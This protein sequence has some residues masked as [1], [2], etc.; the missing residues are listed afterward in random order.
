MTAALNFRLQALILKL[1]QNLRKHAYWLAVALL[2]GMLLSLIIPEAALAKCQPDGV[3]ERAGAGLAGLLDAR[4][5]TMSGNSLYGDYGYA[6]LTWHACDLGGPIAGNEWAG[7]PDAMLDTT[8][9]NAGLGLAKWIAALASGLHAWNSNPSE[10]L[11]PFD[12]TLVQL[13]TFVRE[14]VVEEWAIVS[15]LI[16][17]AFMFV[18][19]ITKEAR[20]AMVSILIFCLAT[21]FLAIVGAQPLRVAQS[22]D[23]VAASIVNNADQRSLAIA[24]IDAAPEEAI[25]AILNDQILYP[26]WAKGALGRDDQTKAGA[27]TYATRLYKAQATT[28]DEANVSAE[29]K[30]NEYEDIF[31]ELGDSED[32]QMQD[33]LRGK[34]YYNRSAMGVGAAIIAAL[35]AGIRIVSEF[36][37]FASVLIFRFIPII[38][39]I[40]AV[41]AMNKFTRGIAREGLNMVG[42]A[43][44]NVVIFGVCASLH[45]AVI[46]FFSARFD[47]APL[48]FAAAIVTYVFWT[49]TR[50]F[51]SLTQLATGGRIN[52]AMHGATDLNPI[53]KL[54]GAWALINTG[55]RLANRNT[56]DSHERGRD[57]DEETGN[58]TNRHSKPS[59]PNYDNPGTWNHDDAYYTEQRNVP[60]PTYN[61]EEDYTQPE[62]A[63]QTYQNRN[64]P[65]PSYNDPQ[66]TEAPYTHTEEHHIIEETRTRTET[67]DAAA[68]AQLDDQHYEREESERIVRAID[69]AS[70]ELRQGQDTANSR[71]SHQG[72]SNQDLV[73]IPRTPNNDIYFNPHIDTETHTRFNQHIFVPQNEPSYEFHDE[74]TS[75]EHRE[76]SLRGEN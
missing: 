53:N 15:L 54:L 46:A 20:K 62:T 52:G 10:T 71:S 59:T 51:R 44:I 38:G 58:D 70:S 8:I 14:L 76:E 6:G 18:W 65:N 75:T 61:Y 72:E 37:I 56:G 23:G 31:D 47:F 3:P 27:D 67:A 25:G 66:P 45:T 9:G 29:D 2:A 12:D 57:I 16:G 48:M 17:A 19:A 60:E 36:L 68:N 63:E 28:Y 21:G 43:A 39:P 22:I 11:K 30:R 74:E 55:Q 24:G 35:V 13:S 69:R 42:A 73:Q 40:F 64:T 4:N 50:P 32:A 33:T 41:L 7:N 34:S 5:S 26:L 49:F 1:T